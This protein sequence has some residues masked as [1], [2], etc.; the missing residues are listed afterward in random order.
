MQRRGDA[1]E[2]PRRIFG[3][4]DGGVARVPIGFRQGGVIAL[5][6]V[7]AE[8][9]ED[10]RRDQADGGDHLTARRIQRLHKSIVPEFPHLAAV[11]ATP[12]GAGS[13]AIAQRSDITRSKVGHAPFNARSPPPPSRWL[14]ASS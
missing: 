8:G 4:E 11:S 5:P 13:S 14:P 1:F 9:A 6:L 10:E 3:K 2:C 7:I 12:A